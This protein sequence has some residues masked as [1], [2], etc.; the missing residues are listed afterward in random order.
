MR[1]EDFSHRVHALRQRAAALRRAGRQDEVTPQEMASTVRELQNALDE[2]R[3]A[4]DEL[5]RQNEELLDS[6]QTLEVQ[7]Q[8]Y[9]DLFEFAPDGYLVTDADG[10][11]WEVN[12]AAAAML[13]TEAR[14]LVRKSLAQYVVPADRDALGDRL[15][16]LRRQEGVREW[17]IHLRPHS[18]PPLVAAIKVAS[19]RGGDDRPL[20]LRWL[21]RDIAERKAVEER[22][23]TLNV[24][25]ESRVRERTEQLET[26]NQLKDDWLAREQEARAQAEIAHW[27]LAFLA[28]A[29]S[30]LA[31][32]L[33]LDVLIERVARLA[34]S[35]LADWDAVHLV[36]SDGAICSVAI[37]HRDPARQK[38][39]DLLKRDFPPTPG[40][41]GIGP[42][43]L[44]G[45]RS[46]LGLDSP[47]TLLTSLAWNEPSRELFQSWGA[48]SAMAVPLVS[49]GRLLGAIT[50]VFSGPGRA[51]RADDLHLAEDFARRAAA[52]IENARL[53]REVREADR[54]KNEFLAMLAHELRNPLAPVRN[55]AH[56]LRRYDARVPA[57][58]RAREVIERQVQHM[59]RLVDDLL[60]VSR[61]TRGKI[62]LRKEQVDVASVVERAVE[63]TRPAFQECRHELV[64]SLPDEP[65]WL[66]ADPTRLEQVLINLLSNA[67]KYTE[68]GGRVELEARRLGDE[69]IVC[70]RDTGMGISADM[71]PHVFELFTQSERALD[72]SQGGLGIGL[73]LVK[74]LVE[75]HGGSIRAASAGSGQGST[76]TISLPVALAAPQ[77]APPE[78]GAAAPAR[79]RRVLLVDDN[80]DALETLGMLIEA[81][82]HEVHIAADGSAALAAA[83]E[84]RPDVVL[85]DIGLPRMDGYEVAR[86]LRRE[87][88]M[89]EALL[90]ALTGYGQEQDRRRSQ[91]AG[92]D[93]HL[94]KPVNPSTLER[95][96]ARPRA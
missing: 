5:R 63:D 82:G 68:P 73:T 74:S 13:G 58:R 65:V 75:M 29:S 6:R 69:A 84:F 39:A 94:V 70:V 81:W 18:G 12:Q 87:P 95:V 96:L 64:V 92:F 20:G 89:D 42:D 78:T 21:L 91:E 26:A 76:F 61:I 62:V 8:R 83:R 38:A 54:H 31:S 55:A 1:E 10:T 23:R 34:V 46:T 28:E 72:R 57:A 2:L 19:I 66:E 79:P 59:T 86:Q 43:A 50:F 51:Y 36:G 32:S 24:E 11:I 3:V 14:H 80:A 45:A 47:P 41:S 37:A 22:I 48:E 9:H 77:P 27:R 88:G 53:Y 93:L 44:R 56:L 71:L 85:L 40:A 4:E 25:L 67:A 30:V 16:D 49:R 52:A 90:A 33:D 7:R 15:D 17:E 60:D 35:R